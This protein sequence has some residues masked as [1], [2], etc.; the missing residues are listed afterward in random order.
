M[1]ILFKSAVK[2]ETKVVKVVLREFY[3]FEVN[4]ISV[5]T[6]QAQGRYISL[7]NCYHLLCVNL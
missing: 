4:T 2:S 5:T 1:A 3:V 6:V 7:T